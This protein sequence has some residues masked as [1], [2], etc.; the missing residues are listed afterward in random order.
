MSPRKNQH[1][2]SRGIALAALCELADKREPIGPV[3]E[4]LFRT[5][6]VQGRDV[7]LVRS[8][9]M[10][11]LRQQDYL[12]WIV[13][14]FSRHPLKKMRSRT[15]IALRLGVYQLLFLDRI[16]A[17]AAVNETVAAFKAGRQPAWLV[18]VVNGILR[19]VAR[20]RNHLPAPDEAMREHPDL[21]NHPPWL[22]ERWRKHFGRS[23][24]QRICL[25]NSAAPPVTL[26]VNTC[27]TE[28]STLQKML[29]AAGIDNRPGKYSDLALLLPDFHGEIAQLPGYS[30]GLFAV[31]DEAAQLAAML[32]AP[33]AEGE[34]ILDGCAGLGG[35]TTHLAA[36]LPPGG[37][38]VAVEPE[39]RRYRLLGE[40]LARL[41]LQRVTTVNAS[42]EEFAAGTE[43]RFSGI[44]LD[45]PCSGTGVIRRRPDIRWNRRPEDLAALRTTQLQLLETAASLLTRGGRLVYAT[46]SLEPEENEEVVEAFLESNSDFQ[47]QDAG[48][49]LPGAARELVTDRGYFQPLPDQGLDGFFAALL[50]RRQSSEDR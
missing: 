41:R 9:V 18:R 37:E 27:L 33:L 32:L 42:L 45:V 17:S 44:F 2:T 31:Q 14:R 23:R 6:N 10:G 1:L 5:H 49:V 8:L 19:N 43:Q 11:V 22:V 21:L 47:L 38:L 36:M 13:A 15:L 40:N 24:C 25:T 35:K 46:C 26:R 28:R 3:L 30:E 39:G 29:A 4:R 48:E 34:Q 50:V 7:A 16:P 12:D 20:E